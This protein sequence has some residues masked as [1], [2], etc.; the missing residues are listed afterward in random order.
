MLRHSLIIALLFT[1]DSGYSQ[2]LSQV[3]FNQAT[4][5]S[6][7]SLATNQNILVRISVDGKILE[8]GTEGTSLYNR[9]YI[10]PKLIPYTGTTGYYQHEPDSILNGKIK[11]IGTCYFTYYG[12]ND[13]PEKAGKIKTAG[14][15][16]F[17]YYGKYEDALMNGRIKSIGTNAISYYTSF[18]NEALKGK[19]KSVGNTLIV[20]YSSFDDPALKGKLK[21]IGPYHYEWSTV[22]STGG[23]VTV[24]K[25]GTQRQLINSITYIPQ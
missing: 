5:F 18:D 19:L 24:L 8:Y 1:L 10:A 11:N 17:D 7:F 9:N 22:S 3:T 25:T 6:W 13:Y 12:S 4:G 15:L 14:N 20:Y 16:S 2:Q 23:F 21:S